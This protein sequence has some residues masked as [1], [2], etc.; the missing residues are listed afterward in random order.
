[1]IVC[2]NI[3]FTLKQQQHLSNLCLWNYWEVHC[4]GLLIRICLDTKHCLSF[5]TACWLL[6]IRKTKF[7]F[8]MVIGLILVY[9]HSVRMLI[10]LILVYSHSVR[11]PAY[12]Y[13]LLV[14]KMCSTSFLGSR[15]RHCLTGGY[16]VVKQQVPGFRLWMWLVEMYILETA[17]GLPTRWHEF[18]AGF[19]G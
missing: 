15:T 19:I 9:S 11:N 1:M 14:S 12:F 13:M 2:F 4:C 10:G 6:R 18:V 17:T 16:Y 3:V 5:Q 8:R 7:E